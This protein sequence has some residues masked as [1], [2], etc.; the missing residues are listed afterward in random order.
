MYPDSTA[1]LEKMSLYVIHLEVLRKIP[2]YISNLN[3]E[4]A[5]ALKTKV[6]RF[7]GSSLFTEASNRCF[8]PYC[9]LLTAYIDDLKS[10]APIYLLKLA[11]EAFFA[12]SFDENNNLESVFFYDVV[13]YTFEGPLV[14]TTHQLS[15][16][17]DLEAV[18]NA[19]AAFYSKPA[20]KTL[21]D[22][23]C[24]SHGQDENYKDLKLHKLMACVR[25]FFV[26][27][28]CVSSC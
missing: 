9:Q 7:L 20:N 27:V 11:A 24:L 3:N 2:G 10:T 13:G 14:L 23:Q 21:K 4:I 17:I 26:V 6:E 16:F 25:Y 1:G 12:L 15:E 22:S 5:E 19:A 8:S 28:T 18:K